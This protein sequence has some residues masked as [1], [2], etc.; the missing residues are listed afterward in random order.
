MAPFKVSFWTMLVSLWLISTGAVNVIQGDW[1]N[2]R[3]ESSSF[4]CEMILQ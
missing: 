4:C 1:D 2:G 3:L